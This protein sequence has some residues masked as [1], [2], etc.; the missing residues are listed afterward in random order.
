MRMLAGR[1]GSDYTGFYRQAE[2][3]MAALADEIFLH[4][5][6]WVGKEAWN[7]H[8]I[9]YRLFRTR[10]AGE[11]F[12]T[13]LDRLLQTPDPMYKDLATVYLLAITLGFRGRYW[14][15]NDSGRID[16]YRRQLFTF[17]FHGQPE[18]HKETKKLFPGG[19][20]PYG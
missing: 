17:I 12:F 6:D 5:L 20:S 10:V 19:L 18:L 11:E 2:Y 3:A 13:R 9:E 1:R 16:F 4:Q 14:S 7:N 15:T 8:L